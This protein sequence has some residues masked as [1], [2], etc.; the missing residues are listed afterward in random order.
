MRR[1]F[2]DILND[3]E[4]DVFAEYH[5]LHMLVFQRCGFY[6][7]MEECFEWMPFA[8]TAYNL[9]DFNERNQFDFENFAYPN[10]FDDLLLLAEYAYNFAY[11]MNSDQELRTLNSISVLHRT[12]AL[13]DKIG[14]RFVQDRGLWVLVPANEGI[15]AAAEVAP[16]AAGNDLF[17]YDYRGYKGDLEGK[18]KILAGLASALEPR[19]ADLNKV[20]KVFMGDYFYL[21]N[22]LNIR[23]N[24]VDPADPGKY[25]SWVAQMPSGEL[26]GW[27][28]TVRDMSA[29]GFLF[30]EYQGKKE[31]IDETKRR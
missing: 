9:Q 21:V 14:Y 3:A 18:R 27:Y 31:E 19:R 22:N 30:L 5:S 6:G 28:D 1:T 26:E 16:K 17:R 10:D 11:V 4:V 23:H 29:A 25:N 24:N 13:T 20:A 2:A 15:E 7:D 8:G 12:D